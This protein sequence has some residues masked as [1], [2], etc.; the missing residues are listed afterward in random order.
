MVELK[1]NMKSGKEH[2]FEYSGDNGFEEACRLRNKITALVKS[3][4]SKND[5]FYGIRK[6]KDE[7]NIKL[8]EIESIAV[9]EIN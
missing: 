8:S 1:I 3:Q 7:I 2:L 5:E 6:E 9:K 4:Y